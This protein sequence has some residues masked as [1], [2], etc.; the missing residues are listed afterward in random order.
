MSNCPFCGVAT[1]AA[2]ETQEA[3]IDALHEEITR[4]RVVLEQVKSTA[5]P[6]PPDDPEIEEN[7]DV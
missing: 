3:C 6:V 5:V 1:A 7:E 4:M 2:H